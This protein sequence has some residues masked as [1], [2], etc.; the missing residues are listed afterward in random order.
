MTSRFRNLWTPHDAR[1]AFHRL[2]RVHRAGRPGRRI[3]GAGRRRARHAAR[4]RAGPEG[5]LQ[6]APP[7]SSSGRA[8]WRAAPAP[9]ACSAWR[10][11]TAAPGSTTPASTSPA[12]P[13]PF[14]RSRP[15][16]PAPTTARLPAR[17]QGGHEGRRARRSA[18]PSS[19]TLDGGSGP[20]QPRPG[21]APSAP[22]SRR[23]R[24]GARPP[25]GP[26]Q[27]KSPRRT[28]SQKTDKR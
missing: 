28:D 20:L 2:D 8:S 19:S 24:P 11:P 15:T 13:S 9:T 6:G 7:P 18:R 4:R 17:P 27:V 3:R 21:A 5:G 23:R 22:D 26:G 16:R 14:S 10:A 1:R 12:W 25:A